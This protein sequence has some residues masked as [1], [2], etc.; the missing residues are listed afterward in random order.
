MGDLTWP[1]LMGA[2]GIL[3][4]SWIL[5]FF[6]FAS[7]R[8]LVR[9]ALVTALGYLICVA[10]GVAAGGVERFPAS[11]VPLLFIPGA[12]FAFFLQWILFRRA[13]VD[14][15]VAIETGIELADPNV[16]R[17]RG[18]QIITIIFGLICALLAAGAVKELL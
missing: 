18:I 9:S 12:T 1:M 6:A 14:E 7:R 8:P 5:S 10:W 17:A 4:F 3:F 15:S 2:I 13:W 11:S 16:E